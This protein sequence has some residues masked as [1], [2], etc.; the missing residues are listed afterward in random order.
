M[1]S[2]VLQGKGVLCVAW[3]L[4]HVYHAIL[5]SVG[6]MLHDPSLSLGDAGVWSTGLPY[7]GSL[8]YLGGIVFEK[9]VGTSRRG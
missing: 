6:Y 9:T 1:K 3:H 4:C 7:G 2:L 8:K 5:S